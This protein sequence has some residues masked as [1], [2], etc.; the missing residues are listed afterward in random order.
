MVML[1]TPPIS[2]SIPLQYSSR[3]SDRFPRAFVDFWFPCGLW[4]CWAYAACFCF[5]MFA[6]FLNDLNMGVQFW[7][8]M[9]FCFVLGG[10]GGLLFRH[11]RVHF[12]LLWSALHLQLESGWSMY[13]L[14][15]ATWTGTVLDREW[16]VKDVKGVSS[17]M[18]VLQELSVWHGWH[19]LHDC[20]KPDLQ[21]MVKAD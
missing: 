5:L 10:G 12:L 19:S 7:C 21:E 11:H 16:T 2:A 1:G 15:H 20:L 6:M 18:M 14:S 4:L 17:S 13:G 3:H 8:K 9:L